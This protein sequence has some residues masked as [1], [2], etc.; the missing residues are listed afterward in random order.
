MN[1]FISKNLALPPD[2]G[3]FKYQYEKCA[4][5]FIS[6]YE[7]GNQHVQP[8]IELKAEMLNDNFTTRKKLCDCWIFEE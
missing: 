4:I 5:D 8:I 2:A 6:E 7:N 1:F 3:Y